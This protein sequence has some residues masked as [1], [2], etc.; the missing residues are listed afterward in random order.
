M[1]R[2]STF[3][4]AGEVAWDSRFKRRG[5]SRPARAARHQDRH[6]EPVGRWHETASCAAGI[7]RSDRRAGHRREL[8]QR[9]TIN[10]SCSTASGPRSPSLLR[11]RPA[12]AEAARS[13]LTRQEQKLPLCVT[14]PHDFWKAL[15]SAECCGLAQL[16]CPKGPR[17][18]NSAFH[19]SPRNWMLPV[20][21][22]AKVVAVPMF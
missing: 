17:E 11:E 13:D 7:D 4:A 1:L 18:M 5:P 16:G 3:S 15:R 9:E 21:R 19:C 20:V 6:V 22:S 8:G 2:L 10:G 14:Y 12:Y